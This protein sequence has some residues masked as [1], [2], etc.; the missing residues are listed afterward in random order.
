MLEEPEAEIAI[1]GSA[2]VEQL[3]A[4]IRSH[5]T[6]HD[7]GRLSASAATDSGSPPLLASVR[8]GQ[9]LSPSTRIVK[10]RVGRLTARVVVRAGTELEEHMVESGVFDLC[11][12]L[13]LESDIAVACDSQLKER[14]SPVDGDLGQAD[15]ESLAT[16]PVGQLVSQMLEDLE[17]RLRPDLDR[18]REKSQRELAHETGRIERYYKSML[19][20][21]G[22]RGTQLPTGEERKTL[23]R[24]RDRRISEEADRHDVRAAVH[25]VQLM[26]WE[27][28]V[29]RT[30]WAL[31][32]TAGERAVFT[33]ERVLAGEQR[34]LLACPHCGSKTLEALDICRYD[35]VACPGCSMVCTV[36]SKTFC[37]DHGL[38][39]CHVDNAPACKEDARTCASCQRQHCSKHEGECSDGGHPACTACLA[40]CAICAKVVCEHHAVATHP[41]SPRGLRRLCKDCVRTCEGGTGEV[42]GPDEVTGCAT[43]DRVVCERH[44]ARCAVDGKVHCSTHLRRTDRS[45]RLVCEKDRSTCKYEPN[46]VLAVDEVRSCTTCGALACSEHTA[47]CVEDEQYHCRTHLSPLH[48]RPGFSACEKHRSTCHVDGNAFTVHGTSVCPVCAKSACARHQKLCAHCGRSVCVA[49]IG[50]ASSGL[51]TTCAKLAVTADPSDDVIAAAVAIPGQADTKPKAW[52]VARDATHTVVELELGWTR[53]LVFVVRHGERRAEKAVAQSVLGRKAVSL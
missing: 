48:D 27:A 35:H 47:L 12:G 6:R 14:N 28:R 30:D 1:V 23:Y 22:G 19:D 34:W 20:D 26:E 9:A 2:F 42:V 16:M 24:E 10:H 31:E 36:C 41:D 17:R 4:V 29:E 43:C 3:I 53:K 37:T 15:A 8:N 49:E 18:V 39:H 7:A 21:I 45:R 33:A 50:V 32:G 52:R 25:P 11:T 40:P 51:C 46:A 5:G 44:Q 38:A 13:A